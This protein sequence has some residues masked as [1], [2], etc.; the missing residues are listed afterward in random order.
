MMVSY[1]RNIQT[2]VDVTC[3]V[4]VTSA[5]VGSAQTVSQLLAA[6]TPSI[7]Q[8]LHIHQLHH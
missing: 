6:V 7:K 1:R 5:S 2:S 4:Y 3:M 8:N